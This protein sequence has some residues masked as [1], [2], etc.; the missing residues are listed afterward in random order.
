MNKLSLLPFLLFLT[1]TAYAA[2]DTAAP[3]IIDPT[4]TVFDSIPKTAT[5]RTFFLVSSDDTSVVRNSSGIVGSTRVRRGRHASIVCEP[6]P[7]AAMKTSVEGMLDARTCKATAAES[8][9]HLLAATVLECTMK[10]TISGLS[11]TMVAD[12]AVRITITDAADTTRTTSYVFR[13]R[14]SK[15]TI[16]TSKYAAWLLQSTIENALREIYTTITR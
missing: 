4:V 6:R 16:D 13:S 1:M 14:N 8:A 15:S 3:I 11:Q 2:S 9:T 7:A 10:E 5:S 12:I